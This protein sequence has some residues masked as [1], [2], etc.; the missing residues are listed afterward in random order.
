MSHSI[1]DLQQ[2]LLQSKLDHL[3]TLVRNG[4]A[5]LSD[6]LGIAQGQPILQAQAPGVINVTSSKP[7]PHMEF[8]APGVIN[9]MEL[10]H[11]HNMEFGIIEPSACVIA[12]RAAQANFRAAHTVGGEIMEMQNLKVSA[13]VPKLHGGGQK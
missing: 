7:G 4:E 9:D 8:Q 10:S 12:I 5:A 11:P 2:L 6:A 3:A 1:N 13:T